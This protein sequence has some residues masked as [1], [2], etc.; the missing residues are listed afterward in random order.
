MITKDYQVSGVRKAL[1]ADD[2]TQAAGTLRSSIF[3]PYLRY[4]IA[5]RVCVVVLLFAAFVFRS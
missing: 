1:V 5:E 3:P 2:D 4:A